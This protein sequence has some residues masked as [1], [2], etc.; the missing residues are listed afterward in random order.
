M[1]AFFTVIATAAILS[2]A[3]CPYSARDTGES[4]SRRA[5]G[6]DGFLEQFVVDDTDSY[7]TTDF[8]TPVD[9]TVSLK[10]GDRGPTLLEDFVFRT[11]ITR[12]DHE[13]I[14]ERAVHARGAAAHGYFE[15]YGDWSN[16]TAA[17]F[18]SSAGKQTPIFLRFSTVAGSRGSSDTVRDVHGFALRFYT[19]EGN[20]DIVGNNIPVFFIQDAIQFPDLIHSVKPRADNEIPQAATAHDSAYDFFSQNPSTLHTL[21]WALSGH[22]VPRSYRH[23]DGFGVHTFRFV[24]RQ[25]QSKLI[26]WH[27][28]SQQG[29]ASLVWAEALTLAGQNPDFHRQD[30]F[31]AIAGGQYPEWEVGVQIVDEE[32]VL[33]YGF[34]L[35]DP[36][37]ILPETLV[38]VTPLGKFVLNRN[39]VNYFAETE[40]AMFSPGHV[41]PGVDFS[42]DP[43]LQGRLFSYVD[44][45]LNRNMGSP[46]FEQIPINRPR[47]GVHNNNRDGAGQQFINSNVNPYTF[48]TL[49]N[50]Y[51]KPA[52]QTVGNGF[53]TAPA[54]RIVDAEY[55]RVVSPT[56]LDYWSQPRLF[57]NSILPVERQMI[58]NALRFEL[59]HVQSLAVRQ[60]VVTQLNRIDNDFAKRVALA[61]NVE[62][63]SPDATYYHDN[64]TTALSI[65]NTTLN[66]IAGLNVGI[67]ATI[68]STTSIQQA[69]S[70]AQQLHEKGANG[71]V[72]AE[73]L[74]QGVNTTY[75]S[76]DA[77]LFDGIIIADDTQSLF[78]PALASTSSF[79]PPQ[80][81]ISIVRD[82]YYYGKPIASVGS[83]TQVITTF[84]ASTEPGLYT[85]NSTEGDFLNEFESGLKQFKFLDRYPIDQP[86]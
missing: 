47:N 54:R 78:D 81:P 38:P 20:Y 80:R 68:N 41:V 3:T 57:Y 13:R 62:A 32:D 21:L 75:I 1:R 6:D 33:K 29:V 52:N 5:P 27:F 53:F 51:P 19:D 64:T 77:V 73:T 86:L 8:G 12:F 69:T 67:L 58:I 39:V 83:A 60:N 2:S 79:Y 48:N 30:L 71:I 9:D 59:S 50:G 35:L 55:V 65:F 56:F 23:I 61:I 85:A 10:A 34:D 70:I 42:D 43:L 40:Q 82:A 11:K 15:S 37:K 26:K 24:N 17:S 28:K 31:N 44:T 25:G 66:T 45:Q 84:A 46:N 74:V 63:P 18:L 16:L 14:P 72:I 76:S 36:T 49:S 22:G 4:L 7:T